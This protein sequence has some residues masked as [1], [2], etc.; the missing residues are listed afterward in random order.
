MIHIDL[1]LFY[2]AN[3]CLK[4]TGNFDGAPVIIED[5]DQTL[6]PNWVTVFAPNATWVVQA[7]SKKTGTSPLGFITI[8][9][10][11][12][13]DVPSGQTADGI[14][15]QIW[16]CIAGDTNQLWRVNHVA[17]NPSI[18]PEYNLLW[19]GPGVVGSKVGVYAC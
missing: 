3:K 18:G 9:G 19:A 2:L 16:T 1:T 5:C 4:A 8:F 14:K 13:L 6:D 17:Q 7:G 12:C 15:L 10:N 11:K